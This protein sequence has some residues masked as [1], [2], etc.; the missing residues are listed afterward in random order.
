MG[1][2]RD[3]E[4]RPED[5]A[6][7]RAQL[8]GNRTRGGANGPVAADPPVVAGQRYFNG[9]PNCN[10]HDPM[11]QRTCFYALEESSARPHV[12]S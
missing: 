7:L 6:Q 9:G 4:S 8:H 2:S 12:T 3:P 11:N 1:G 5:L 10:R